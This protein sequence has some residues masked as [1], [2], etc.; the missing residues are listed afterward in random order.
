MEPKPISNRDV[1]G[2]AMNRNHLAAGVLALALLGVMGA[3]AQQTG[4]TTP[5]P[6]DSSQPP[7]K[8]TH[9][10]TVTVTAPGEVRTEQSIDQSTLLEAAPGT[11]P[12]KALSQLP[13][14]NFTTADPYGSYEWA[15]R[16][17]VRGFNQNQLGF[18]L[19]DVPLGDMSYGNWNGLHISRAIMDEN[20]GRVVLS[21]GTGALETA[22]NSNLGGTIQFY[23]VDPSDKRGF[24]IDQSF[25]SYNAFRSVARLESGLLPGHIKFD[26]SG[27]YQIA[28]KWKGAGDIGQNYWQLNG[29]L[30]KYVGATGILTAFLDYSDRREVDYQDLSKVYVNKLGYNFDNYG[31]WAQS[32]QAAN[33]CN[34][35]GSYPGAVNNLTAAEDPCDAGYYGGGG[36]RKDYIG[37]LSYKTTLTAHTIWK[38]TVYGHG[39]DGIGL[40][41]SPY[42]P[43]P[44]GSPIS[45]RSSEYG[46]KRGGFITSLAYETGRNKLEGGAWFED[47]S[48]DLAR[49]FYATTLASP[50]QSLSDFPTNPF[51]TQWAYNFAT[52]VYQLHLQDSYKINN[53]VT[54]SAGFKA[55]ETNTNGTHPATFSSTSYAQGTLESGKPFLP[56]FGINWKVNKT[57]EVFADGAYNVRAYVAGGP[58]FGN[59]PWGTTQAGFDYLKTT[60]KPETSWS[61]EVGYRTTR[62][63]VSA[64][65]NYF[66]VNFSERLLA[67]Q[68]GAGILGN[69][70]LLSNVGGVTTNGADVAATVQLGYGLSLYNGGTF[71]QSTYDQNVTSNGVTY[72][73]QGK[74]VVDAPKW[75]YKT[76]LAWRKK[77]IDT[78][79]GGD[80]MTK[81]Y[82]TY[83]DDGSVA[84]RFVA[85]LGA[86][87]TRA[88]WGALQDVKIQMNVSNLLNRKYY[89]SIGTNGFVMNDPTGVV[90]TLQVGA[91][92]TVMATLSARF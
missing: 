53:A 29:K 51:A 41:F 30:V 8:L 74:L 12:I 34:G 36:L 10:E 26:L 82:Y 54:V 84:G 68:Q 69:P 48:F 61:E 7:A 14:V 13:S 9:T 43:S 32:I 49:R 50:S 91:P 44:N 55:V 20:I 52:T 42:T 66:H 60:L 90:D 18:T 46:I 86:G 70:S 17:S 92:R 76:Q 19:D 45:M 16:I 40:W 33:A 73:T 83:T 27:D 87:Y 67:I 58:G 5:P 47:E 71:S 79:I 6:G 4:T 38:T 77:G 89:S 11:S 78:H 72:L 39:D 31:N 37:G 21:Q 24:T 22:S 15:T 28:D 25:G 35:N 3:G 80:Y 23:S 64:Q 85:D 65:V 1:N 2:E 62:N 88:E 75:L 59:A 63:K 56:Q 81:R 57:D